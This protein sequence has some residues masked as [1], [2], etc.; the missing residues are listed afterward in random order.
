VCH[1]DGG[2]AALDRA[3][4]ARH[5][6]VETMTTKA[7]A[8]PMPTGAVQEASRPEHEAKSA[9]ELAVM[10]T[11][12]SADQTLMSWV[13][14]AVTMITFG[15]TL[16]K[17]LRYVRTEVVEDFGERARERNLALAIIAVGTVT[18]FFA[19]FEHVLYQRE[20]GRSTARAAL[21]LPVFLA[22]LVVLLGCL[23]VVGVV[24]HAGPF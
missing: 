18:L 16:Y 13:R 15:F 12:M 6:I 5:V 11:I 19:V 21:R 9:D 4:A 2:A 7:G 20:L 17:F 1:R 3:R 10:R 23:A 22:G 24:F 8:A 14:T